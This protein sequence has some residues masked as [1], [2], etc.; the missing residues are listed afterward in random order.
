[1]AVRDFMADDITEIN[2]LLNNELGKEVSADELRETVSEMMLDENYRIFV[3]EQ[4]NEI[5]GFIGVHFGLA[6][7]IK[8]KVMRI[9]ALAVKESY[10][11]RG[12]GAELLKVAEKCAAQNEASVIGVNSGLQRAVA[13]SFYEKQKFVKKA[14]SF[15]KN[16]ELTE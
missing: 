11:H 15:T 5:V 3:A 14:Y 10:Q 13:H 9:I 7:E 2:K 8:G 16:I 4:N 1:M 6:F 12:I